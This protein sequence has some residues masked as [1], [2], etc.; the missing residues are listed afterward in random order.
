MK[1]AGH[2]LRVNVA[3]RRRRK[4]HPPPPVPQW[5]F[6]KRKLDVCTYHN[7]MPKIYRLLI[8]LL[9]Q[10]LKRRFLEALYIKGK[11]NH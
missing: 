1:D 2:M 6:L 5:L 11:G 9:F 8:Q 3:E 7:D 4:P 10:E